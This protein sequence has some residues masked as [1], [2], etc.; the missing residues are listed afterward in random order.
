MREREEK[1]EEG[2]KK[3]MGKMQKKHEMSRVIKCK[4]LKLSASPEKKNI[5]KSSSSE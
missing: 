1:D 5:V 2:L 4:T 3:A